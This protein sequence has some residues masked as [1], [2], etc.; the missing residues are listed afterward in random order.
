MGEYLLP[1]NV[2]KVLKWAALIALPAIAVFYSTAA[3]YWGWPDTEAV[4]VTVNA[5]GVLIGTLIGVSQA[6]AS[7]AEKKEA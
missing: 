3:P 4:V 1:D 6:K 7:A 2:Y 5:V